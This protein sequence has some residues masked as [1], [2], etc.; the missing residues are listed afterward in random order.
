MLHFLPDL[1]ESERLVPDEECTATPVHASA[2]E[3]PGL[4]PASGVLHRAHGASAETGRWL[5]DFL[6]QEI[7]TIFRKEFPSFAQ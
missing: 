2:P 4:V 6:I 3:P 1:V 7:A 5:V